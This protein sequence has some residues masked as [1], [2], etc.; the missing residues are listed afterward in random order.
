MRSGWIG[1]VLI[2]AVLLGSAACGDRDGA[3]AQTRPSGPP[4]KLVPR[5]VLKP[6]PIDTATAFALSAA[7]RAA[8]SRALGSVVRVNVTARVDAAALGLP[9]DHP[10]SGEQRRTRGN[11]SGFVMDDEGH[12]ITNDHVVANAERVSVVFA[13]G[14]E[15]EA[16]VIGSDPN[17]DVGVI[18]VDPSLTGELEPIRFGD[19]DS[20]RV[21]DW[22]LALGNP[23]ELNFTVTT[24]IVSAKGRDL[25]I[26]RNADNTA[27]EAFIQTDAAI[28]PGNSGGPLVDLLG[29]VVGVNGA[30]ETRTGYFSGAGFAIPINLARKVADDLIRYGVV[31]RPRLGVVIQDVNG[32]DAEV[33]R[34]P[35]VSGV[36]IASVT[37]GL[38]A[39]KAGLH[40]SDVVVA[41][42][43]EP[44]RTVAELQDRV[45]RLQPGD[46]VN[47]G[48]IRDG[49]TL[50][51]TVELAQFKPAPER[52]S[53]AARRSTGAAL[54]GF[55]IE[56]APRDQAVRVGLSED[57][58][59]WINAID[60]F[61]PAIDAGLP[62][63]VILI[64]INGQEIH[65]VRDFDRILDHLE[66][67]HIA[68]VV[69][70]DPRSAEPA[71]TIFN[72]RL[73]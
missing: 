8:A 40:M 50:D 29:Q 2:W 15:F 11:G 52:L 19:S 20:L 70:L 58:S 28:N 67:G 68:S 44:V 10:R 31:H 73:R 41:L 53:L 22:V 57:N 69:V 35:S 32:A 64:S 46:R 34:L 36:E 59:V 6:L 65:S 66:A 14:R 1:G 45:A 30:I 17:T 16:E 9:A 42:N 71:P 60:R 47:L 39:E 33:Y 18:R 72:Y 23:L 38:P 5:T 61:G 26:L 21:G 13:D 37:P 56:A 12:I 63:G 7:F 27:L 54:L 48:I 3:S 49:A 25:N 4:P 24:G 62:P 55:S 51:K 43:G